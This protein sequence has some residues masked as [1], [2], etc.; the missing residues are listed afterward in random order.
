MLARFVEP[1]TTSS[2]HVGF[3]TVAVFIPLT[4]FQS[5]IFF[6]LRYFNPSASA[7]TISAQSGLIIGC[8]TAAHVCTGLLWGRLAD[9]IRIG[10]KTV[11]VVGLLAS[12]LATLGYGISGSFKAALIWQML[13]GALNATIAMVRCMTAELNPEKR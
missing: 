1:L 10:R 3:L 4:L 6:Q 7:A 2:I 9:H 13:D 12:S 5:Y 8:K 11:L